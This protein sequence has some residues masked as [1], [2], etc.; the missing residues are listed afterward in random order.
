MAGEKEAWHKARLE[1]SQVS[2]DIHGGQV[3]TGSQP[4][5][6]ALGPISIHSGSS[7]P[8]SPSHLSIPTLGMS[9]SYLRTGPSSAETGPQVPT[10]P[11][12]PC[13]MEQRNFWKLPGLW[14]WKEVWE[15]VPTLTFLPSNL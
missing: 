5:L 10:Q 7:D 1:S 11:P 15:K 2:V 3:L 14:E 4:V 13:P 6:S 8:S 12:S 9:C